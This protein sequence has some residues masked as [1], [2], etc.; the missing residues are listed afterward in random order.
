MSFVDRRVET[1]PSSGE[2][3]FGLHEV[4][5]SRTDGRGVIQAGNY[6]FRRVGAYP[7]EELIGA[8]HKL[9]R[10]PDMPKGVFSLFWDTIQR[11]DPMGAYVKNKSKDGLYYWVFAVV[12]PC[13][14]GYLSARIKPS[15]K[16]F[17]E[18]R[19]FYAQMLKREKDQGVKPE[20]SA[21]YLLDWLGS[22]GYENYHQ[23][24]A[25]ALSQELIA[26]DTGLSNQPH[27]RIRELTGML[28]NAETLVEETEG[29]IADFDA[30]HTIPHNLRVLASR[31]EPSGGPVTVLS[32]NYGSMSREMSDWFAAHVMGKNSNFAK[33]KS[34]VNNSL[35]VEGMA[36]I[37][38]EC[39][40]QLQKERRELGNV[41]ME[42]ERKILGD[43]VKDQVKRSQD[44]MKEVDQEAERIT[45]ACQVMHRHFLGLSSTRVLLKIESARLTD[46]GETLADIIDQLGGFQER[47][48]RRLDRIGKLSEEIRLLEQ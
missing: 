22:H 3:P 11:G 1:R 39:D 12:V 14:D 8:P 38:I 21:Q 30:M 13:Q 32:Q 26:R 44:G 35:F 27:A 37:L 41:D 48:S 2:A 17:G 25:H 43:L 36:R 19:A 4:F 34:S 46:S 31:I 40:N 33:I 15:S 9:I 24:A 29:L 42:A 20:D 18:V 7:W 28:R 10:H 47:I 5:F 6:V 23:F 16:L 45:S